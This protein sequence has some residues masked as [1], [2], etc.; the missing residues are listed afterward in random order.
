LVKAAL[1]PRAR[2]GHCVASSTSGQAHGRRAAP[3][4][5]AQHF[6]SGEVF[7]AT[8]HP[9]L[10]GVVA[11]ELVSPEIGATSVAPGRAGV[12]FRHE[13]LY[14]YWQ[15]HCL[16]FACT[17]PPVAAFRRT[18]LAQTPVAWTALCMYLAL[19]P[20]THTNTSPCAE[21][22]WR[23]GIGPTCGCARRYGRCAYFLV[24]FSHACLEHL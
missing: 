8:C 13:S 14:V 21:E 12:H 7:Y 5:T 23:R 16:C 17:Y 4:L 1:H 19:P 6:A 24:T 15:C 9:G 3:D 18:Y 22:R 10:E 2:A 11:E 20:L